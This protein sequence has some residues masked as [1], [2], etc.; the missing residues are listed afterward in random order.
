M[1]DEALAQEREEHIQRLLGEPVHVYYDVGTVAAPIDVQL[2]RKGDLYQLV[3]VGMS[4]RPMK[5]PEELE[6]GDQHALAELVMALPG[7]WLPYFPDGIEDPERTWPVRLLGALAALPHQHQSWL[8]MGH[9]VP[10]TQGPYHPSTKLRCALL[11]PPLTAP[12]DFRQLRLSNGQVVSFHGVVLLYA[13]EA[14]QKLDNGLRMLLDAFEK[15]FGGLMG[16][17]RA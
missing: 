8:G 2:F 4:D 5:V 10:S 1:I 12:R 16:P 13:E 6:D 3:T 14:Q 9:T 15:P 7:D 17:L 11:L